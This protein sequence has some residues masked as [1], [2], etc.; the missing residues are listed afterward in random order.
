MLNSKNME[1]D[2]VPQ[3]STVCFHK[4]I[5]IYMKEERLHKRSECMYTCYIYLKDDELRSCPQDRP[6]K[7]L[8]VEE[9]EKFVNQWN[10]G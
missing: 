5:Y 7:V 1:V 8:I 2:I 3:N 4:K 6:P 9:E 10:G